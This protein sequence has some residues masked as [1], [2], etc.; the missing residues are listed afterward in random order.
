MSIFDRFRSPEERERRERER[1]EQAAVQERQRAAEQER[2]AAAEAEAQRAYVQEVLGPELAAMNVESAEEA[3]VAIKLAKLRKK[4]LQADKR[5]LSSELADHR[6]AWRERTAG[7]YST[8]ALGRGTGGRMLRAGIQAKRR[9][10]RQEHASTVNAFSD[11]KQEI[12]RK[13]AQIDRFIIELE[14]IAAR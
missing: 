1:A 3:K 10:E 4:E 7:R 2:R 12:D 8:V 5:E 11:A 6:E 13:I 14:R 9:S